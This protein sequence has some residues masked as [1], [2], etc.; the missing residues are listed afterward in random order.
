MNLVELKFDLN[1][2]M[3]IIAKTIAQSKRKSLVVCYNV[4]C[5]HKFVSVLTG[6]A[7]THR[8]TFN[9]IAIVTKISPNTLLLV[10]FAD[11]HLHRS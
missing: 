5:R 1:K 7:A 3:T 11:R 4:L 10:T 2:S 8:R 9:S 6:L